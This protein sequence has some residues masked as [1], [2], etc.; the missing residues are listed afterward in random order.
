M[1]YIKEVL[2]AAIV[3]GIISRLSPESITGGGK[4]VRYAAALAFLCV[5]AMP[6][7]QKLSALSD[8]IS[9]IGNV[10][11]TAA[12]EDGAN[13]ADASQSG[14]G[15]ISREICRA[16]ANAAAEHFSV[17][18]DTFELRV[19]FEGTDGGELSIAE[20]TVYMRETSGVP[21]GGEAEAFFSDIF[22]CEVE[23]VKDE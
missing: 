2:F 11:D 9:G 3:C 17:P 7:S 15:I 10:E 6:F 22:N 14:I 12:V 8:L 21:D 16:A 5:L 4:L 18:A 23:V 19:R 13:E 1:N 20:A